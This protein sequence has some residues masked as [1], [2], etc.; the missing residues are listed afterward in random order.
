MCLFGDGVYLDLIIYGVFFIGI[1]IY[2]D[3]LEVYVECYWEVGKVWKY[4]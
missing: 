2:E 3:L 1:N 4:L